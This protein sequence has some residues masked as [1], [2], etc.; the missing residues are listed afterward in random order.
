MPVPSLYTD[1]IYQ[2]TVGVGLIH[3]SESYLPLIY[4]II[5][6]VFENGSWNLGKFERD[7]NYI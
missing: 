3:V 2:Q 7:I 5:I 1:G 4:G 6:F